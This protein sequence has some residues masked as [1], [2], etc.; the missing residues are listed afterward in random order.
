MM[1]F[2]LTMIIMINSGTTTEMTTIV[3]EY[4]TKQKCETAKEL[5][6][7]GLSTGKVILATCTER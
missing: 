1:P 4:A 5:N 3:Q 6:R 2:I 7:T